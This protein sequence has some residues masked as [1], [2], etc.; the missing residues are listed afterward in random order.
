[1][2]TLE[3]YLDKYNNQKISKDIYNKYELFDYYS[4]DIFVEDLDFLL[5]HVYDIELVDNKKARL[6][7]KEFRNELIKKYDNKCIISNS[8]CLTELDACHIIEHA[9]ETNYS[10][11]N[12]LLLKKNLHAS[13]D[14]NLWCIN[15]N[16]LTIEIKKD[17]NVGEIKLYENNK[18]NIDID[19][20]LYL[21]L[22]S[23]Y[24]LF[25]NK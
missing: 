21:N 19:N 24:K 10:V 12:G 1:M 25:I 2:I 3:D 4:K 17:I 6:N 15:P 13:F 5:K 23:K 14:N 8:D 20:D 9:E 11:S 7:Q 22:L 16:T 18:I